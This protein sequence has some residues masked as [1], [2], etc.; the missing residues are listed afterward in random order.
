[1][2]ESADNPVPRAQYRM[3]TDE[4]LGQW[5]RT[6]SQADRNAVHK[7]LFA[8]LD[9]SLF[10]TYRIVENVQMQNELYVIVKDDL[11]LKL[12]VNDI[13]DVDSFDIL[14]IGPPDHFSTPHDGQHI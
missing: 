3:E 14:D 12:R 5:A 7:A 10:Q 8:M 13:N 11:V 9:G 4:V 1:M 6:A 2:N